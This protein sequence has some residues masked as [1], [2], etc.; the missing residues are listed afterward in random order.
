MDK[1]TDCE[2]L[3]TQVEVL[4]QI[5]DIKKKKKNRQPNLNN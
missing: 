4:T 1:Q 2:V 5:K 3:T